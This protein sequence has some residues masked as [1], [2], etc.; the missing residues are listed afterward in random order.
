MSDQ[1]FSFENPIRLYRNTTLNQQKV[2]LT[3]SPIP[4]VE[5]LWKLT[6]GDAR[7]TIAV[8][9]GPVDTSHPC[10]T[11]ASLQSIPLW[12]GNSAGCQKAGV[13]SC[14]HG[15]QIASL[16]F[17]QHGSGPVHGIAPRCRG[18]I[19]PIFRDDPRMEGRVLPASQSTLAQAIDLAREHGAHIINISSGEPSTDGKAEAQLAAAVKRCTDAG[20]L[21]VSAAGNDGCDCLHIPAALPYILVVGSLDATGKP[22]GFSNF[23]TLYRGQGILVPGENLAVAT[24]GGGYTTQSGTSFAAPLVAGVAALLLSLSIS[25]NGDKNHQ[26]NAL[27]IRD[28]L[29]K[30]AQQCDL[31]NP[32]ACRRYLVGS[33]DSN[34]ALDLLN[35]GESTMP[36]QT[37]TDNTADNMP[38]TVSQEV[39]GSEPQT[40]SNVNE[41]SNS[42]DNLDA[43]QSYKETVQSEPAPAVRRSPGPTAFIPERN[44]ASTFRDRSPPRVTPSGAGGKCTA[45]EGNA[46]G[47]NAIQLVYALGEV[48]FDFGTQARLD[49]IAS[50]IAQL[51]ADGKIPSENGRVT[52]GT[53]LSPTV[54]TFDLLNYFGVQPWVAASIIWTLNLDAMPI[55]AIR[56]KGPYAAE[57]Y[58]I[59]L[60]FLKEQ[61]DPDQRAERNAIPG[62]IAGSVR[63]SSGQLLP[64]I[65]PEARGMANWKTSVL[66]EAVAGSPEDTDEY[67]AKT[68]GITNFLNRV[69]YE[70]RNL[71]VDPRDRALNFAATNAYNLQ[72]VFQ[73]SASRGLQLDQIEVVASPICRTDSDCWDIVLYFFNPDRVLEEARTA[74]RFTADVSDIVPVLIGP[75]REWSVR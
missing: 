70:V 16:I 54:S 74:Y 23:G 64:V 35:Q 39:S 30:S 65:N 14:L 24:L 36:D 69:Y 18:L 43:W 28:L 71:G 55:Y 66:V 52:G 58:A 26:V 42:N 6:K 57:T 56:A 68:A 51:K 33:L 40:S 73:A 60:N 12:A 45:C 27:H 44:M 59:L 3:A 72:Q 50:E 34:K 17:A 15:T 46:E 19:I 8:I 61:L 53:L 49:A 20:V 47:N 31:A 10:F 37:L 4:G 63:L 5:V 67:R 21:I 41:S 2:P 22:S 62:I 9:D 48:G 38:A 29:L 11:G 1:G 7:V 13:G 75:V 32:V 25:K